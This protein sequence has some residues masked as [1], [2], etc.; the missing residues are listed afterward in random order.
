M[1]ISELTITDS[2]LL[3]NIDWIHG[4]IKILSKDKKVRIFS[5]K[6]MLESNDKPIRPSLI[7]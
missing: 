6:L 1:S 7:H 3:K 5:S 2:D 4:D